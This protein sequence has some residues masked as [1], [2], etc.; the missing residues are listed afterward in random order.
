MSNR[1]N[2]FLDGF[3]DRNLFQDDKLSALV[4]EAKGLV[5]TLNGNPYGVQ[6]NEVLR[7]KVTTDFS[8]L[9][10]AIDAAIEEM[11]R[12]RIHLDVAD[13]GSLPDAA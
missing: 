7:Q 8:N 10:T 12:R 11:P 5:K 13:R 1:I 2:E 9:K 6:Y 3:A 4:E